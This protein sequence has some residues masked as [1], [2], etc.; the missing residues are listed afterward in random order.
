MFDDL[1]TQQPSV[2]DGIDAVEPTGADS[3]LHVK[4]EVDETALAL[5]DEIDEPEE[6]EV[7]SS[8]TAA[9]EYVPQDLNRLYKIYVESPTAE[10]LNVLSAD[11][12]NYALRLAHKTC[13]KYENPRVSTEYG[14]DIATNAVIKIIQKISK[15]EGKSKF[16]SWCG[17]TIVR[18]AID[19]LNAIS[20]RGELR[21]LD[22]KDLE[23][24]TGAEVGYRNR[25]NKGA[26]PDDFGE[27]AN[28][29][30]DAGGVG[31]APVVSEQYVRA[32]ET[33][34]ATDLDLVNVVARM[35]P[36]D[37]RVLQLYREGYK[38]AEIATK[39]GGTT[40]QISTQLERVKIL[41][42]HELHIHGAT[43]HTCKASVV[44][45][46]EMAAGLRY[47]EEGDDFRVLPERCN[48]KKGLTRLETD[49]LIRTGEASHIL[50]IVD[51]K[52]AILRGEIWAQQA[53]RT[54]RCGLSSTKAGI[55]RSVE[56]NRLDK[57]KVDVEYEITIAE[58]QK[59]IRVVPADE[60][61]RGQKAQIGVVTS[62]KVDPSWIF[63][64]PAPKKIVVVKPA[65]GYTKTEG[66]MPQ[67]SPEREAENARRSYELAHPCCC[68]R[69]DCIFF[70]GIADEALAGFGGSNVS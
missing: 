7:P 17:T 11:L 10:N 31:G 59:L 27:G 8:T 56:G 3:L 67:W 48:C 60:Y 21:V 22:W 46:S 49:A 47:V 5:F 36:E 4:S 34:L 26:S 44:V 62:T 23:S 70:H 61:D 52:T 39:I 50:Q 37:R 1:S 64:A 63:V 57:L 30:G 9:P 29:S 33:A 43:L 42:Q 32:N 18:S 68:H 58:R 53:V 65:V 15:F 14:H 51:G 16:S 12:Y 69:V 45:V 24:P 2:Y 55:E 40:R 6:D 28:D 19:T 38:P 35:E 13:A 25:S 66:P 41:L 54:P 20:K